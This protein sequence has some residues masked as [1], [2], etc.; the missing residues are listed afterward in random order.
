MSFDI[1]T[2]TPTLPP[3]DTVPYDGDPL[4]YETATWGERIVTVAATIGAVLVVAIIAV[5]MS[6]A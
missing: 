4:T 5:L 3:A 1:K 6:M 2:A